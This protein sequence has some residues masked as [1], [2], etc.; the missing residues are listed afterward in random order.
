MVKLA[1]EIE[2][3]SSDV[4][5]NGVVFYPTFNVPVMYVAIQIVRSLVT[6]VGRQHRI[7]ACWFFGV[8][9]VLCREVHIRAS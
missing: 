6:L 4:F 8:C 9:D 5:D 3:A 2:E 7:R 1:E